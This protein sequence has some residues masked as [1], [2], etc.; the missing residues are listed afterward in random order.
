M[1]HNE[2]DQ[3]ILDL[4]RDIQSGVF[5]PKDLSKELR[6]SCVEVLLLEGYSIA[7]LAKILGVSDKSIRRDKTEI[8]A[9]NAVS[10]S[11]DMAKA[12][13]GEL[14]ARTE[15]SISHLTRLARSKEGSLAERSQAEYLAWKVLE[16]RTKLLQS[17][18]YLPQTPKTVVAD[19]THHLSGDSD[20]KSFGEI[21]SIL[22]EV[23]SV[24]QESGTLTP[25]IREMVDGLN[26]RV[27]K[28]KLQEEAEKLLL[29]QKESIR[30]E[31]E[32]N[33]Q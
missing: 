23:V 6:Q 22:N 27:T 7:A 16:E 21:T 33:G 9:R 30:K 25:Q 5:D 1:D 31:G 32:E 28:L 14:I 2:K 11:F 15:G 24:T 3:A 18:G 26:A 13:V 12:Y 10:P 17:L 4:V 8:N 29:S 20:E 19:F